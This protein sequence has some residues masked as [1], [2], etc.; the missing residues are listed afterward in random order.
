M[1]TNLKDGRPVFFA[2][3]TKLMNT[4][5]VNFS[6]MVTLSALEFT[7]FQDKGKECTRAPKKII[8]F[9]DGK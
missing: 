6:E 4:L 8:I 7:P 1:N 2:W 5:K 9:A 3:K